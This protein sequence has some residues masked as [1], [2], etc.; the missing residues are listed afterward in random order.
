MKLSISLACLASCLYALSLSFAAGPG[1]KATL[2]PIFGD[3]TAS[4]FVAQW[5]AAPRVQLLLDGGIAQGACVVVTQDARR[6]PSQVH[7]ELA[8]TLIDKKARVIWVFVNGEVFEDAE[9]RALIWSF[10]HDIF[11]REG[12]EI[13]RPRFAHADPPPQTTSTG[14]WLVGPEAIASHLSTDC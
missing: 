2:V 13:V 3:A 4:Q 7:K 14:R 5:K 8:K 11:G 10:V 6:K 9:I 12:Y 1:E